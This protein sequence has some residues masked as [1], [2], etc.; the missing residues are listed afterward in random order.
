MNP[1]A[2]G[3]GPR[4]WITVYTGNSGLTHY[5]Y[6]LARALRESGAEITLVTNRNYELDFLPAKFPIEKIFRRS[7]YFP[8]DIFRFWRKFRQRRPDVVHYQSFLK[9]PALELL[10]LELQKRSGAGLICTAHDWLPHHRRFYHRALFG[11][12]YRSFDRVIVHSDAGKRFLMD[13]LG[14]KAECLLEIPHGNYGFL[15]TDGSLTRASARQRLGLEPERLWFLFFGRIDP[16]KGL[17]LALRALA[18][19]KPEEV[20]PPPPGLIIA[21]NPE[22]ESL[23]KYNR[24]ITELGIGNRVKLFPGHIPVEEIQLYFQAADAV[25][26]PYRESSTSGVA[27]LAMGFGKPVVATAVGGLVDVIEDGVN[28]LLVPP[29]DLPALASA[30]ELVAGDPVTRGRLG[31]GWSESRERYS[32]AAIAAQTLKVYEMVDK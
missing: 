14:V 23:E 21:G 22:A 29:D 31:Q 25:V 24:L 16:H 8:V 5:S 28:G 2:A 10:L 11:R 15:S 27:H 4:I 3:E 18:E 32:W 13:V 19:I 30:L 6:C 20:E 17:D 12:Y 7:R 26:L 1:V 9:F